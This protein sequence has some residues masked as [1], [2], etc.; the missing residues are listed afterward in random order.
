MSENYKNHC[1]NLM[2]NAKNKQKGSNFKDKSLNVV[3]DFALGRI[4]IIY[5]RFTKV[6]INLIITQKLL[7]FISK[8]LNYKYNFTHKYV[9]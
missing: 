9:K 1:N 6:E 8:L 7:C 4:M 5:K 2:V 3:V